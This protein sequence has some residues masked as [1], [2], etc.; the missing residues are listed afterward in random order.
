MFFQSHPSPDLG[1]FVFICS[2]T[3]MMLAI[4]SASL[5]LGV[6][7]RVLAEFIHE[8]SNIKGVIS[9]PTKRWYCRPIMLALV[10]S[11][12]LNLTFAMCYIT[13]VWGITHFLEL[14]S[15]MFLIISLLLNILIPGQLSSMVFGLLARRLVAATEATVA[16][17]SKLLVQDGSFNCESDFSVAMQAMS[18]LDA[19]IR[20]VWSESTVSLLRVRSE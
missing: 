9:H 12:M 19:V 20:E 11:S 16:T 1:I 5:T 14:S 3:V 10:T 4:N 18:E 2:V 8:L 7:S 17:V 13:S 6:K 15:S